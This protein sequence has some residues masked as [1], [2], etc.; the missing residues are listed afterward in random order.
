MR[1]D[2]FQGK[3]IWA[4]VGM[5]TTLGVAGWLVPLP[6]TVW[7]KAFGTWAA[8]AGVVNEWQQW[9]GKTLL[10]A[11]PEPHV[12]AR[13]RFISQGWYSRA[14]FVLLGFA[15]ATGHGALFPGPPAYWPFHAYALWAWLSNGWIFG[16]ITHFFFT[17]QYATPFRAWLQ[18]AA[19]LAGPVGFL[20]HPAIPPR[21]FSDERR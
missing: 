15:V 19:A 17:G 7:V 11:L 4:I 8:L 2:L 9:A 14:Y 6:I 5:L 20:L 21:D 12:F 1:K 16:P 18:V 3:I 10:A 13:R